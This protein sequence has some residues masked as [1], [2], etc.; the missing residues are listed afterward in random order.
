MSGLMRIIVMGQQAFGKDVLAKLLDSGTDEVVAVYCEPDRGGKV[1]P[2]KEF[3][4]ERGLPVHQPPD[5]EDQ[6]ALYHARWPRGR[7][8]DHG[9]RERLRSGS[10]TR[11][12]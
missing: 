9:F 5:F 4:L 10:G 8:L 2:I 6:E 7:P 12:T 1:D 3:A 11:Y